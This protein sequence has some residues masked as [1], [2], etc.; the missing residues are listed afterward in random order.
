MPALPHRRYLAIFAA[1]TA[2][3]LATVGVVNWRVDPLQY[4]RKA[5]YPPDFADQM[6][7]QN[8][9]LARNYPYDSLILGT[10]VSLGFTSAQFRE[11]F[12]WE[13]INLAMSGASAHEQSL[14][15]QVALRTGRVQ[16]VFWDINHEYLRGDPNWVSDYDGAFP[17]YFY[18]EN[19]WSKIPNYLLNIDAAK[20]SARILLKRCGLPAYH[21][22]KLEELS[23]LHPTHHIGRES[24]LASYRKALT[25]PIF[26]RD[27]VRD[28]APEVTAKSFEVNY[29]ALIRAHPEVTFELWFPPYSVARD[30]LLQASDPTVLADLFA[31]KRYVLEQTAPLPNVHLHDFQG[32]AEL[33]QNLDHYSD[34]VHFDDDI[35]ARILSAV[36]GR[37]A[38]AT[39]A[40]LERSEAAI[41]EAVAQFQEQNPTTVKPS[42]GSEK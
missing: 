30:A 9:G 27:H 11:N 10:S 37:N 21:P 3:F 2:A 16:R 42:E 15:L 18:E 4:Y 40:S 20:S 17:A 26:F 24:V 34:T 36:S 23:A 7:Y 32:A 14:L 12:G 41:R 35:R 28:F 8:P 25:P 38:I 22:R 29:L 19:P 33:A 6:R 13:A 39:P 5:A 1:L 31:F